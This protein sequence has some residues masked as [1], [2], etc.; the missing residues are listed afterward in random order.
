[1]TDIKVNDRQLKVVSELASYQLILEKKIKDKEQELS[2][3]KDQHKQVSQ[4]DLPEALAETGLSE[5]KLLDGSK[6]SVNQFYNASIP[7]DK[8]EQA[9]TWLRDNGH[10]DL[11]KN[12]ITCD[13]GRGEDGNAKVLKE[14]LTGSG[15]SY[16]DKTAVHPQTLKAFVREQVESGQNLPLDLLGVYIGQ[17]SVIKGG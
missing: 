13:F 11:I 5:I 9:F 15:V 6:I 7:K 2:T 3:L 10:E 16:T 8:V 12:T 17:K 1:M 14:T 4:T